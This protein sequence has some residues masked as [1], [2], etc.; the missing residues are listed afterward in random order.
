MTGPRFFGWVIGGSHP[1]GVAADWL[2]SAWGQN[3]GNHHAAPV[4]GG[5]RGGRGGLAAGSARSSARELGRLRDRRN[6]GEFRLPRRGARRG[7]APRRMGC[8]G[9]RPVRSA[10]DHGPSRRRRAYDRL[11]GASV[12]RA[13]PRS[14]GP[15]QGRRKGRMRCRRLSPRGA[16][17]ARA[18]DRDRSGRPGQHRRLR[19]VRRHH[20]RR[21]RSRTPGS[22]S[23]APSGCGRG[24]A[25]H[26]AIS[27]T[28]STGATPGRPTGTNG[29]R[30][31]TTAAMR[32]CA[33]RMR[34]GAR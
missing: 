5:G 12:S 25:R 15:H 7:A 32:S 8:R 19:S 28:A 17:P 26:C 4:G 9:E 14:R 21:A 2:T 6:G 30:R 20:A 31:P 3:A 24:R 34:I 16:A 10:A 1:V 33:T 29:C 22:M 11:F 23:T 27:R 13:R 18:V